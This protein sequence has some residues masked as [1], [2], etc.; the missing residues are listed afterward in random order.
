VKLQEEPEQF[1]AC[2]TLT[3][4]QTSVLL[5][6]RQAGSMSRQHYAHH[7]GSCAWAGRERDE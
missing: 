7:S 4:A 1:Y 2:V 6:L 5:T 3:G